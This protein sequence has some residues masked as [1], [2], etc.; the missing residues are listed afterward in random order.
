M[1]MLTR[2]NFLLF[3]KEKYIFLFCNLS[4]VSVV[5][6]LVWIVLQI[7]YTTKLV[8]LHVNIFFGID[9]I[10]SWFGLF[11]Y[12]FLSL[13]LLA[14]NVTVAYRI[15]PKDKYL[16]YYLTIASA[17]C[18]VLNLLYLVSLKLYTL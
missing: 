17:F 3:Y 1:A 18:S 6:A 10:G 4:A 2:T 13:V 8:P 7:P 15:F 12:P 5:L 16:S 9:R 14:A 11:I